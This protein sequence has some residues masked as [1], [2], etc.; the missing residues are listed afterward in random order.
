MQRKI[1]H[2]DCDCFFAAIEI[3]D[4][5]HLKGLP[6]AVGGQPDQRGVI[7]TCNYEARAL[8]VRAA[9]PSS[10]ARRI[11]PTLVILPPNMEKYRLASKQILAIYRTYTDLVEPLS[12]DEAFLDVST[13]PYHHGSATLIAQ[14]IRARILETVG[15]TASAGIAANKFIA[16]IASDWNKPDGL[17]VVRPEQSEAF[18]APLPVKKIFGVGQVTEKKLHHLGIKT[19]ADLRVWHVQKLK[20]QFGA[21][22]ERLYALCRGMDDRAVNPYRQ[23]KSVSVENTYPQDIPHLDSCLD[24]LDVLYERL[25]ERIARVENHHGI[26]GLFAKLRFHDFRQTTVECLGTVPDQSTFCRLIEN[27]YS[28]YHKPVR[29]IGIGVRIAATK[30]MGPGVSSPFMPREQE[31]SPYQPTLF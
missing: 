28:R 2:C 16:K 20:V 9:M 14:E 22:G 8:G 4:N 24:K 26:K 27:A 18:V 5:P 3:R 10:S 19:C 17:F 25:T 1:I 31:R 13:S 12:L 21:L 30:E 29:L 11:C 6:V 15:I 7:A 23:R